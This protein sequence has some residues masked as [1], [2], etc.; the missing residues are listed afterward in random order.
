[1]PTR[2][3]RVGRGEGGDLLF[4]SPIFSSRA[5][6]FCISEDRAASASP[7]LNVPVCGLHLSLSLSLSLSF[8]PSNESARGISGQREQKIVLIVLLITC[9]ASCKS[10][11]SATQAEAS[12]RKVRFF[13]N[14][15]SRFQN[16]HSEVAEEGDQKGQTNESDRWF[17][18]LAIPLGEL[19]NYDMDQSSATVAVEINRRR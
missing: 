4:L 13:Q 2:S 8:C 19:I 18:N 14:L 9:A 1:M 16:G 10:C 7:L 3:G 17:S 5:S 12:A 11:L 6:E 15:E